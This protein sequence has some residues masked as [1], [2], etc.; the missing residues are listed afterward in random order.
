MTTI[1]EF[2]LECRKHGTSVQDGEIVYETV[3]VCANKFREAVTK[4]EQSR[5]G[6]L[7]V[8]V[9]SVKRLYTQVIE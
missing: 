5:P 6:Y 2:D 1:W 4:A 9:I 3:R 7:T 8:F